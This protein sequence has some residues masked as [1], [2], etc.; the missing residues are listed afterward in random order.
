VPGSTSWWTDYAPAPIMR[1][2]DDR[3]CGLGFPFGRCWSG[4]SVRVGTGVV[5]RTGL[6]KGLG[7]GIDATTLE[8]NAARRSIVRRDGGESY[9][10]SLR[11]LAKASGIETP[12]REDLA[13]LDRKRKKRTSNKKWKSPA[14]EDAR[15]AKMK[16]GRTHWARKFEHVVDLDTGA[17]VAVTLQAVVQGDTTTLEETLCAAVIPTVIPF[18]ERMDHGGSSF[19]MLVWR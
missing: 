5:G 1:D 9:E 6:L 2:L 12:T 8:A 19:N 4:I 17:M 13:Q 14:D 7:M 3:R 10:Q 11:G 18:L 15:I 16:G